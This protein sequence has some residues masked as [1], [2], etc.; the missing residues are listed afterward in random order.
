MIK[1]SYAYL[2][3][4]LVIAAAVVYFLG[5]HFW[6]DE[7][8]RAFLSGI[9]IALTPV[10]LY[11]GHDRAKSEQEQEKKRTA[12]FRGIYL[13][14][15][16]QYGYVKTLSDQYDKEQSVYL[17]YCPPIPPMA[18]EAAYI[19][20][21][22]DIQDKFCQDLR[23][24]Y[25]SMRN[26]R[27]IMERTLDIHF[28]STLPKNVSNELISGSD[29]TMRQMCTSLKTAIIDTKAE[30]EK[31]FNIPGDEVKRLEEEARERITIAF[32]GIRI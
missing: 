8:A 3:L 22:I 29:Q 2:A 18:W 25:S 30:L 21:Y 20:G 7:S 31:R 1:R 13:E 12:I 26:L 4:V 6:P 27:D 17:M 9:M 14:I 10:V 23:A 15:L 11:I 5:G 16:E 32:G 19:N 24:V 28:Y